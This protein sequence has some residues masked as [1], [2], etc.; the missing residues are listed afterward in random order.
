MPYLR[1]SASGFPCGERGNHQVSR[2]IR[3]RLADIEKVLLIRKKL[4]PAVAG[5]LEFGIERGQTYR[6][7]TAGVDTVQTIGSSAKKNHAVRGPCTSP[8]F[9]NTAY[10]H[11]A[12][13]GE[14]ES[15]ELSLREECHGVAI[16]RPERVGRILAAS[17]H[18][19]VR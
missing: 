1:S 9:R 4:R 2:R 18:A 6:F 16:R 12:R 11:E 19:H 17:D 3:R 8:S 7:A 14:I 13:C 10:G 5:F 15:F